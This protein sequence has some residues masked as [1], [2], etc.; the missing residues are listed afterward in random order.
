MRLSVFG[1]WVMDFTIG[2][3]SR[4]TSVS[5]ETIRYYESIGLL[6]EARRSISGRRLFEPHHVDTL[7][8]IKSARHMEFSI[9]DIR[10]LLAFRKNGSC[11][12]VKSIAASHLQ[13][14]RRKVHTLSNLERMLSG[15][16]ARCPGGKSLTDCTILELLSAS[17]SRTASPAYH[18]RQ[19]SIPSDR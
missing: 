4:R 16:L 8:F 7:A 12:D 10:K 11:D 3:L 19:A 18:S 2:E 9:A 5:I 17:T 15:A 6:H 14:L 1:A 13:Q